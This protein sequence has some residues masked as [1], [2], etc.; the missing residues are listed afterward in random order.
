MMNTKDNVA[1]ALENLD[2][3]DLTSVILP[4]Q[5]KYKEVT[6][7]QSLPAGHKI[8]LGGISKGDKVLK[9]GERIGTAS[10]DIELGE[11][12]HTHNVKSDR[13]QMPEVWYREER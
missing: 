1:T 12:V 8:A 3:G 5:E 7:K 11:Y 10:R 13:M 2:A 4:S 6:A 9:Y